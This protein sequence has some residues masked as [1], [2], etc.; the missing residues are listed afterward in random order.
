MDEVRADGLADYA[1]VEFRSV[2][3]WGVLRWPSVYGVL[4]PRPLVWR[5]VAARGLG[6]ALSRLGGVGGVHAQALRE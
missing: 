1:A 5:P 4:V 6:H 3:A 2:V